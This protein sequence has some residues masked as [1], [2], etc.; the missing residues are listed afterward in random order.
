MA[1]YKIEWR[2]SAAKEIRKLPKEVIRRVLL[3]VEGLAVDPNPPGAIKLHGTDHTYH[4]RVGDYRVVYTV[5][6]TVLRV[7]IVRVRHRSDAY[8]GL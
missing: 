1:T 7:E 3:A 4:L 6:E 5:E 2:R 8:R